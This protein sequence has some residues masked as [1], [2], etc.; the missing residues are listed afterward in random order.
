[1]ENKEY[2]YNL[3]NDWYSE[4]YITTNSKRK[5]VQDRIRNYINGLSHNFITEIY[6]QSVST[7]ISYSHFESDVDEFLILLKSKIK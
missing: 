3:V 5:I 1:M 7:P 2:V 4:Y 6:P